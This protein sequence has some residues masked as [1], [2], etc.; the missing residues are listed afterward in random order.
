MI[1]GCTDLGDRHA[2]LGPHRTGKPCLE[3]RRLSGKD[4][5]VLT[6]PIVAGVERLSR[7]RTVEP[8]RASE[9]RQPAVRQ[10]GL[11][12]LPAA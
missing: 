6:L 3:I 2:G 5:D 10:Q 1:P 7:R 4:Q 9:R 8:T 11:D 12:V